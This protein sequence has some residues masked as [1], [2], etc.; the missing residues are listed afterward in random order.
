MRILFTVLLS[1]LFISCAGDRPADAPSP[2]NEAE[3][4]A[5]RE[6]GTLTFYREGDGEIVT[7]AIE[8]AATEQAITRGLMGRERLPDRSGML[9][10][11]PQTRIQ[12]F[13]MSNTPLSLDITFVGPDSTVI[14]TVKYTRPFSPESHASEAPARF[15]VE[16][17]AG[18][19][20]SFGIVPGDRVRWTRN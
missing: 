19:T 4:V 12:T 8:I 17:R 13:W 3:A 14:N 2:T 5:F 10:L 20:D 7:I 18:F 1:M 16:T 6:D 15:V 11:M 9:F